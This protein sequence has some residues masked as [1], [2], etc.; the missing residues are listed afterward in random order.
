MASPF[1]IVI[2]VYEGFDLLDMAGPRE[3]FVW[4]GNYDS[5]REI[6]VIVAAEKKGNV[7]AYTPSPPGEPPRPGLQVVAAHSF[8]DIDHVDLLWVPGGAVESLKREMKNPEYMNFLKRV[9]KDAT[10]V[11]S[12]CEGALLLAHAGLLDGFE[13]TTHWAFIPCLQQ[14]YP[15]VKV[16]PGYPRFIVDDH[17]GKLTKGIRVTGGGISSGLDES[18][19]LILV[20]AGQEVA[21]QV[22]TVTQYFPSPPVNGT[23]PGATSCPLWS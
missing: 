18:L 14:H 3:M 21:E 1:K 12:V 7:W 11:A 15:K 22:Q 10:Y 16:A 19:K 20:A 9:A 8:A 5:T 23:I 2:P 17:N 6:Q 13:V 4:W